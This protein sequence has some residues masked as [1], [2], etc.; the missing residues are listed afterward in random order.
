M[1]S[2]RRFRVC[3][4]RACMIW[5]CLV[6]AS[7]ARAEATL[8]TVVS[9]NLCADLLALQLAAPAQLLSVSR[10]SQ[11]PSLSPLAAQ[12]LQFSANDSSAEEIITLKPDIVLA[13]KRWQS[14]HQSALFA[15]HGMRL[16]VV[17]FPLTW[18]EIFDTTRT[19]ADALQRRAVAEELIA[20][21]EQR[22]AALQQQRRPFQVL[23]LRPNGGSAGRHT[24][25][26][27]VLASVGAIN[28]AT[29]TGHVGWGRFPLEKLL[30]QPP[31]VFLLGDFARD[32][33]YARN[34]YA[35]HPQLQQ[36]LAQTPHAQ[37]N[38]NHWGCGNWQLIEA[39]EAIAAQLDA[40]PPVHTRSEVQL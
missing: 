33:A 38:G 28:H 17:S 40:L 15:R 3:L 21:V 16:V 32:A 31:D 11:D 34:T 7:L 10:K 14:R 4:L 39:A 8:P 1:R 27:T 25:V 19:V 9:T 24:Y 36:L 13:S 29:A 26:D 18:E 5:T 2:G 20:N 30:V 23:Y 6:W 37:L 35:R 22:L 12:A